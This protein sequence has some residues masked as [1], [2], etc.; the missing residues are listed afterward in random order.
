M[1]IDLSAGIYNNMPKPPGLPEVEVWAFPLKI[2]G[3]S[4]S[5]VR[6]VAVID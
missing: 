4:G 3:G 5:P 6:L 2:M 1:L